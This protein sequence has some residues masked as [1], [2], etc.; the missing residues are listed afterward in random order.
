[1]RSA[2]SAAAWV[3]H[4]FGGK[5]VAELAARHPDR[6]ERA[7]LLDPAMHVD[8]AV[9]GERADLTR[10]DVSFADAEEA[11][12]ARLAD[13]SLFT[14]PRETLE[15]EA[16]EHL[17][18][19][20]DGRFRWQYAPAAVIVAWSEMAEPTPPWPRCPTLVVCGERSWIPVVVPRN[21]HITQVDRPRRPQRPLGRL[22]RDRRRDRALPRLTARRNELHGAAIREILKG[23]LGVTPRGGAPG[24]RRE[25]ET[26][27]PL[28]VV[29]AALAIAA[30]AIG[31]PSAV[32]SHTPAPT[33][34]T[35][36]GSL[37][38]ELGCPGD[39]D[40]GLRR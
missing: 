5:L 24:P 23:L 8:P 39:W 34:V 35:I 21:G 14:T 2:I 16:R 13:G 15:E 3:G 40:P 18:E 28:R 17:V 27:R 26:M 30:V 9:A 7:V 10:A 4:S 33:S 19:S 36:A 37:Q 31:I 1:M 32:A 6:V 25:G 22:R 38:S 12:E 20:P 29:L 11:I